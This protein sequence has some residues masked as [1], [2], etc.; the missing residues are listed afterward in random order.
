LTGRQ[1]DQPSRRSRGPD[2][3]WTRWAHFRTVELDR[4]ST[5]LNQPV[6]NG[7]LCGRT[8]QQTDEGHVPF[9]WLNRSIPISWPGGCCE[10]PP[11]RLP[12]AYLLTHAVSGGTCQLILR[13]TSLSF[14]TSRLCL[15]LPAPFV[16]AALPVAVAVSRGGQ[17]CRV[18][19]GGQCCGVRGLP[20]VSTCGSSA[21]AKPSNARA[22]SRDAEGALDCGYCA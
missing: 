7:T 14:Q 15:H 16:L 19:R 11:G 1:Q 5:A 18:S 9:T 20:G 6:A 21:A 8:D 13:L 3:C 12:P 2:S 22:T 10:H 17:C 4:V